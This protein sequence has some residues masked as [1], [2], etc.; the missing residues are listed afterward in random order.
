MMNIMNSLLESLFIIIYDEYHDS[1][2]ES[3]FIIIYDEYHEFIIGI[4]IYH[5]LFIIGIIIIG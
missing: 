1:L 4:I 3:L 2:L 5:N